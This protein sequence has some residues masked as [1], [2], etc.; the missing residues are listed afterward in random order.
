MWQEA[1]DEGGGGSRFAHH[2]LEVG[3]GLD[4]DGLGAAGGRLGGHSHGVR[5]AAGDAAGLANSLG[6]GVG[7]SYFDGGG[8]ANG[9]WVGVVGVLVEGK[10]GRIRAVAHLVHELIIC[11]MKKCD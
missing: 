8:H 1:L 4:A 9:I 11:N 6:V 5:V 7:G 3:A 10:A 2:G